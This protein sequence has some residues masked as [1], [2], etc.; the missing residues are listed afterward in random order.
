MSGNFVSVD[1][2]LYRDIF[3]VGCD[4]GCRE[5]KEVFGENR[6]IF[7]DQGLCIDLLITLG[8]SNIF[9]VTVH[10]WF[11]C[12][13]KNSLKFCIISNLF[14]LSSRKLVLLHDMQASGGTL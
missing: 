1:L 7:S 13:Y 11:S 12:K 6:V 14:L 5:G 2:A 9:W 3:S 8:P 10:K 4:M